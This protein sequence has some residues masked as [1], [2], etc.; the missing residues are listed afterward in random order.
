MDKKL[1]RL[2]E[3]DLHRIIKESVNKVLSEVYQDNNG[4]FQDIDYSDIR[5]NAYTD[6]R[7]GH[8]VFNGRNDMMNYIKDGYGMDKGNGLK[9]IGRQLKRGGQV[10]K[11]IGNAMLGKVA[12]HLD[13]G[14]DKI[15]GK[16]Y[17]EQ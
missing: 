9:K 2:T 12:G 13:N 15:R 11:V 14:I 17:M 4:T 1:I 8:N 6:T 3:S 7:K 10:G 16:R 5:G